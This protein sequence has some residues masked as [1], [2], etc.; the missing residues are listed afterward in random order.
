MNKNN[1]V[2]VSFN[3]SSRT[4]DT[5]KY[6]EY[7][8]TKKEALEKV[9]YWIDCGYC[10]CVMRVWEYQEYEKQKDL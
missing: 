6:I 4:I 10:P 3:I 8:S 1:Y 2:V 5:R 9:R 7:F